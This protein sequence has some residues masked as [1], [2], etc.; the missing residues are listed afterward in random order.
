MIHRGNAILSLEA[1]SERRVAHKATIIRTIAACGLA[2]VVSACATPY[3]EMGLLGGVEAVQIDS[4]TLRVSARGNGFTDIRKMK[5]YALLKAAEE[6][7]AHGYDVFEVIG[8]ENVT[9]TLHQSSTSYA[10]APVTVF[11]PNGPSFG[12]ASVPVSSSETVIKP[13]EDIVIRMF[14]GQKASDAPGNVF[15]ARE[16]I[17][18]LGRGILGADVAK[19]EP[20]ASV[21]AAPGATESDSE[22]SDSEKEP[23]S[24][25]SPKSPACDATQAAKLAELARRSGFQYRSICGK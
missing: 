15:A 5:D 1:K 19:I 18:F 3:Q 2:A 6:T 10:Y 23:H 7:V 13:G 12:G 22:V 11:G 20:A 9:R 16:V 14:K 17:A 8:T 25:R 21:Q 24:D 4:N